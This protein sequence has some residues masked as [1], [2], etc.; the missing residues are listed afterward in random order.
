MQIQ[1]KIEQFLEERI[2]KN[3]LRS[4]KS[5]TKINSKICEFCNK[6][7]IDFCSNDYLSFSSEKKLIE[8]SIKWLQK[9]GT[10]FPASRLVSGTVKEIVEL[11]EKI[12]EWKNTES[13]LIIGSGFLANSSVIPALADRHSAIF[14][15][16]LNHA[17]LNHG[18]IASGA[19]FNRY[20]HLDYQHLEELL[21]NSQNQGKIIV[22]DTI[23][24]M[25]GDC[26]DIEELYY[27]SKKYDAF[28]YLDDAHATGV[29]GK[30]GEGVDL[31]FADDFSNLLVM[32][33]FSKGMGCYGAYVA[34]TRKNIDYLIN[35]CASFI[36][37]TALPPA[38]Y[39]SISAAIELCRQEE[40]R[41][42]AA[43]ILKNTE[44]FRNELKKLKL[45]CGNSKTQI[46][47]IIFGSNSNTLS[48]SAKL[49]ENGILALAIRPPTVP[50]N[51]ARIRISVCAHHDKNDIQKFLQSI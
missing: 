5:L 11:E 19:Q 34:G 3:T 22:S 33:T 43:K 24:S 18:C 10:S 13:A 15:D 17:S 8:E 41:K 7:L 42:R 23:F 30:K 25:E 46:I 4:L 40:I 38:V 50:E 6:T 2:K 51:S 35:A 29:F 39:G 48:V 36:Y 27:L 32:G 9:F 1:K 37:S 44:Y 12:A 28:L 26:A 45:N 21:R 49:L 31:S 47:P 14:A 16:R 20:K